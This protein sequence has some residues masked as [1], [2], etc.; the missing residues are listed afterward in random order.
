MYL[1]T[2][3]GRF[4]IMLYLV[5]I[6]IYI[7]TSVGR[8]N[9]PYSVNLVLPIWHVTSSVNIGRKIYMPDMACYYIYQYW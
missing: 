5:Y 3:V 6:Y 8:Y 4:S 7:S 2:N 1:S 9:M